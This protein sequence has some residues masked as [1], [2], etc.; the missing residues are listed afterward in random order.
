MVVSLPTQ[1]SMPG[2][3]GSVSFEVERRAALSRRKRLVQ[4][5]ARAGNGRK[6]LP[7]PPVNPMPYR[8]R[9]AAVREFSHGTERLRDAGGPVTAFTL[10][11]RWLMPP[12]V[13]ATSPRAIRDVL[14]VR[15]DSVDK[16]TPVFDQMRNIMAPTWPTSRSS[17]GR[18]VGARSSR[19]SRSSASTNSVLRWRRRH[20]PCAMDGVGRRH[21][22]GRRVP[23]A[24]V[25]RP[26]RRRARD[27][28]GRP[29]RRGRRAAAGRA[30]LRDGACDPSTARTEVV[31]DTR[32][33]AR[34]AATA[35][36][37]TL[38]RQI[39]DDCRADPTGWRRWCGRSLPPRTR[40]PE[41]AVGRRDLRRADHFHLR[42]PR[43]HGDDVDVCPVVTGP[44]P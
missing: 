23:R 33:A 1:I 36:L 42:R 13:L 21:R 6:S 8:E 22:S 16:T 4:V 20:R 44:P 3:L 32:P 19:C 40:K 14:S 25:A 31:A 35:Q 10:G 38:T 34:T 12:M 37:Q 43:H 5:P 28:P 27:R 24:D 7:R 11:P 41:T 15:D 30:D 39:L 29:G 26:R 18:R 17:R 2:R 9:L